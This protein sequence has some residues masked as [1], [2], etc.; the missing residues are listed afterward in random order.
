[1]SSNNRKKLLD[2]IRILFEKTDDEHYLDTY[3]II[4]EL[5]LLGHEKTD[6]K[7]IETSIKFMIEEL[8]YGIEKEKGAPNRYRWVDRTF[9]LA[10]LKLLVDAVQSCRFI[11]DKK[12]KAIIDN[13]K[14]LTSAAKAEQLDRKI[15]TSNTF[16]R[17]N[18]SVLYSIDAISEAI[19]M[20][21][22]L[23]FT[24]VD[25]GTDMKE[26]PRYDGKLH[27]VSPYALLWNNDYYYMLGIDT[28]DVSKV[29]TYRVDRMKDTLLL[30]EPA[31]PAPKDFSLDKYSSR[32][33]DMFTGVTAQVEIECRKPYLMNY[34]ID[35]F[36]KDFKVLSTE[37]DGSFRVS[38]MVD[39]SPT[40]YAWIFQFGGD[41]KIV[42]PSKVCEEFAA[43]LD[44]QR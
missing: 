10:E 23:N 17:D 4:E 19:R 33:F 30:Y 3:Q 8:G 6:R 24:M 44:A 26:H 22:R 21:R 2:M 7:T 39:A 20:N 40:F 25:F 34:L 43:M 41:A 16:K 32:V 37:E 42:A 35:R 14:S 13:L 11:S 1:M 31:I 29:K 38:V 9:E 28:E 36:G 5:E 18:S 15:V 27:E 12:S